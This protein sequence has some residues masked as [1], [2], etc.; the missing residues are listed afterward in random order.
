MHDAAGDATTETVAH[1][2]AMARALLTAYNTGTPDAMQAHWNLTWHRREWSGMRTYVQ[3]DLGRVPGP[4]VEISFDDARWLVARENGHENWESLLREIATAAIP[5]ERM[6]R[7][8]GW[9]HATQGES[10]PPVSRSTDWSAVLRALHDSRTTQLVAHGQMTDA[11]AAQ[12]AQL[13]HLTALHLDGSQQLSDTGVRALA[14]L[15]NLHH[16]DL[17]GTGI[18]DEALSAIGAMPALTSLSL[19]WTRVTDAG[20]AALRTLDKLVRI[21][22]S[23]TRSGDGAV[24]ALAGMPSLR[25]FR[26]GSDTTDDGI[27]AFRDY[28][29]FAAWQG[30]EIEMGLTS[31]TAEPNSLTLRGQVTDRG[32]AQLASLNG[33]FALDVDDANLR[34]TARALEPLVDLPHLGWLAFDVKDDAMPVIARFK[35]L[36]FLLCQD[37]TASDAAWA[38]LGASQ[39]IE[40]IWGRRCH[41]LGDR[42][43]TALSRM[44]KLARLSVSC[45]NVS[46]TALAALPAFPAL[47]EL[48]PMDIPDDGY[49]HIGACNDL[50][51]LVL[52]YCRN[53]T[54]AATRHITR[55]PKLVS[56]FAS[57]TQI[58]D[59]T[60][61]R[62]SGMDSLERVTF[63]SCAGL[64][65]D[66]V[67][68]LARLPRLTRVRLS[69][70]RLTADV[71]SRF[72]ADVTVHFSM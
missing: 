25:H 68:A 31:P 56:Y 30:G 39:S 2:D 37:T 48:M 11:R 7:P 63:D 67:V 41:G 29:A 26:G 32:I 59:E 44:P 5:V 8:M 9:K 57:Y 42:G 27:P 51:S 13:T 50:D 35:A 18:T 55:L 52:M 61:R 14:K 21:D 70:Q 22:L 58:T 65:D 36:R 47:R 1:Y 19:A 28:P 49:R 53:T 15:P 17:Q 20:I 24:R 40:S 38:A 4:D 12:L 69:G 54:D 33:L 3:I 6:L 60:P 23:G 45:L 10:D 71:K 62:L 16:L 64:T 34:L 43:F 72:P 66:G 46:D